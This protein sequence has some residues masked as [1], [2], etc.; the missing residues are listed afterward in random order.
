M[1]PDVKIKPD[2][3]DQTMNIHNTSASRANFKLQLQREQALEIER[4]EQI[5]DLQ[6]HHTQHEH[7]QPQQQTQLH[8]QLQQQ[9]PQQN[10]FFPNSNPVNFQAP[11]NNVQSKGIKASLPI[12]NLPS[13]VLKVFLRF[14]FIQSCSRL[15]MLSCIL[16]F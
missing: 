9:Q 1:D 14:L 11:R 12:M 7:I 8:Q 5:K 15:T 4:K 6:Q 13:S 2:P 3:D 10:R 16:N